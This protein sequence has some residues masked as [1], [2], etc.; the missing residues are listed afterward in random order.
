MAK[1]IKQ[2]VLNDHRRIGKK[3]IPPIIDKLGSI[4]QETSWIKLTIP[5]LIWIALLNYRCGYKEGTDLSLS[6]A[7]ATKEATGKIEWY[8]PLSSFSILTK[9]QKNRII[10]ILKQE[11]KLDKLIVGL[12]PLIYLYPQLPLNF[13][14]KTKKLNKEEKEIYLSQMRNILDKLYDKYSKEATFTQANALYICFVL[15]KLQVTSDS[16][17]ANFPEIENYPKTEESKKI[18][19]SIRA[20]INGFIGLDIA[21]NVTNWPNY[22]WNRGLQIDKC[23]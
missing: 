9:K 14:T 11:V 21:G 23:E 19:A 7:K 1:K 22:F 3:F 16:S 8:A 2:T 20:S 12:N 13:I 15:G 10:E 4:F 17:L 5:E 18:A 6:L